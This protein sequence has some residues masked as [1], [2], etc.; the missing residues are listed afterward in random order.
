MFKTQ[1]N[2]PLSISHKLDLFG[3][4]VTEVAETNLLPGIFCTTFLVEIAQIFLEDIYLLLFF[5]NLHS[6]FIVWQT[7]SVI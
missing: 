1:T 7:Y 3:S 5:S 4:L 2:H 6:I